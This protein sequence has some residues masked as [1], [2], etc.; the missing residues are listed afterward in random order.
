LNL[1]QISE[2]TTPDL[3]LLTVARSQGRIDV[4]IGFSLF[5]GDVVGLSVVIHY[6]TSKIYAPTHNLAT[7]HRILFVMAFCCDYVL[8]QHFEPNY[9]YG[10]FLSIRTLRASSSKLV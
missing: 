2:G 5:G 3:N 10:R 7:Y 9:L 4:V 8:E 6:E 1:S